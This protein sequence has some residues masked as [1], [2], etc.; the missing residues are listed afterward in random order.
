MYCKLDCVEDKI[1]VQLEAAGRRAAAYWF[2]DGLPEILFGTVYVVWGSFGLAWRFHPSNRWML[3]A[4]AVVGVA[5]FLLWYKDRVILDF[6]KARLTYPRTGYVRPPN[7]PV[8]DSRLEVVTLRTAP[9]FDWNVTSFRMRTAFV[10][11][12]SGAFVDCPLWAGRWSVP[13]VM[14]VVAVAVY[15]WN[16]RDAHPYSWQSALAIALAGLLSAGLEVPL[17]GRRYIPLLIGGLWLLGHGVPTLVRY[18]RTYPA[19]KGEGA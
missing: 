13:I 1:A 10:F 6:C 15:S 8:P 7:E 14:A 17:D 11:F 19:H 18:L 4:Y 5:F 3:A 16:R 2:I 9:P 12:V